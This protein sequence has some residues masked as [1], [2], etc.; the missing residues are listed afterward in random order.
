MTATSTDLARASMARLTEPGG[1]LD[2]DS[3]RAAMMMAML[4]LLA[5]GRPVARPAAE[6][7]LAETGVQ[8]RRISEFL[9]SWTQRD[10]DGAIVGLGLTQRPT[11][12]RI[13]LDGAPQLWAWCA[14][15]TLLFTRLLGRPSSIESTPPSASSTV[16]LTLDPHSVKTTDPAEAVITIPIRTNDEVDVSSTEAIWRTYC[17]HSYFFATRTDAE[18]WA[19]DRDDIAII[20]VAEGFAIA[21]TMADAVLRNATATASKNPDTTAAS[22]QLGEA[23]REHAFRRL[24]RER[25][26][27]TTTWLA[28]QLGHP[29]PEIAAAT[30][31]MANRGR[32]RLDGHGAITGAA[33][34]SITPDRHQIDLPQGRFWTWCHYDILGIFG[35]LDADGQATITE[36]AP[37]S[38]RFRHG[39]PDTTDLV[40]LLPDRETI[41][42]DCCGD[43]YAQWCPHANLFPDEATAGTWAQE[44]GIRARIIP[45]TEAAYIATSAWKPLI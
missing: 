41:D 33:G 39:R 1:A 20:T 22:Q 40:L 44:H 8:G 11:G 16:T 43:T 10:S 25:T 24:L 45:I 42:E 19:A 38:L 17:H 36:P 37:L 32:L 2:R 35:A 21:G 4:W 7:A 15:D 12:H 14:L 34:L 18:A 28:T 27:V 31:D 23:I 26:P 3:G 30:T 6:A 5:D 29:Q 9:D 13:T